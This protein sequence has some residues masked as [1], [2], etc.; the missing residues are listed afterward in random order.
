M[1]DDASLLSNRRRLRTGDALFQAGDVGDSA[2]VVQIGLVG[3][4]VTSANAERLIVHL[5]WPGD[6]VAPGRLLAPG[7]RHELTARALTAVELTMIRPGEPMDSTGY[8]D[9][10]VSALT[11]QLSS[12]VGRCGEA[13]FASARTRVSRA[14]LRLARQSDAACVSQDVVASLA[15]VVRATANAELRRL[16]DEGAVRLRRRQVTIIDRAALETERW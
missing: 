14:V 2:Q 8:R 5:C 3:L 1:S 11:E 15:G 16:E 10:C 9:R 7:S 6:V 13:T 4:E 12:I